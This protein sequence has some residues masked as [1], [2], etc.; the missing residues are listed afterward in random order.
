M[1]QGARSGLVL[2]EVIVAMT[3]M[4]V[5]GLALL[6]LAGESAHVAARAQA[7]AAA[8]QRASDLLDAVALWPREDLDRHL[9]DRAEGPWILGVSHGVSDI[10]VVTLR[11]STSSTPLLSTALYRA[12][13]GHVAP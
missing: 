13:D 7:S 12:D 1:T 6:M 10:Y 11:D 3:I 2:L 8:V 4:S 5:S 9:G